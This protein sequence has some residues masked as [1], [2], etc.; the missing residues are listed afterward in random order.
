MLYD[1]L[2]KGYSLDKKKDSTEKETKSNEII[3]NENEEENTLIHRQ[4]NAETKELDN[5]DQNAKS[6]KDDKGCETDEV[7]AVLCH[8]FG[9]WSL[10]HN[11]VNLMISFVCII[12]PYQQSFFH[13]SNLCKQTRV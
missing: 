13:R 3:S 4:T 6:K 12:Y 1:T 5:E 2:I 7:L 11:L 9:H 8:E 10:R